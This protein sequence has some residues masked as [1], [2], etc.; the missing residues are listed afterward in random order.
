MN[1]QTTIEKLKSLRLGAMSELYYRSIHE[2]Q[3]PKYTTDEFIALMVDQEWE[4]RYNRKIALLVKNARFSMNALASDIDYT[5]NRNLDKNVFQRLLTLNFIKEAENVIIT[6]PT[7]VGKSHLAQALGTEACTFTNKTLYYNWLDFSEQVKLAKLEGT[8]LKLIL[9]I[10]NCDLLI[11]DDFGLNPFDNYTR[12]ALMNIVE[13]KYNKSSI[14]ITSQVPVSSWHEIIGEG[15]IADAILD[16]LV[17]ASHRI[18][19]QGESLRKKRTL[20]G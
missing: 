6:G 11:L 4:A 9:K 20:K 2:K 1:T 13:T 12:Q 3:F 5:S 14:I 8:Y 17:H 18:E 16:R 19:L 7:G 15:T 10:Q